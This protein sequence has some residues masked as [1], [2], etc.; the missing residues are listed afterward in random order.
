MTGDTGK[1]GLYAFGIYAYRLAGAH[2]AK[3][4][5]RAR[6]GSSKHAHISLQSLVT[7]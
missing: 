6:I 7:D 2:C 4:A 1:H 3:Q 5:Y